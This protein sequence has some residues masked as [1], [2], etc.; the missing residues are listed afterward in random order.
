MAII[1]IVL[2]IL[3]TL[4]AVSAEDVNLTDDSLEANLDDAIVEDLSLS[5][6]DDADLEASSEDNVG[7]ANSAAEDVKASFKTSNCTTYIKGDSF[8][9]KLLD[10]KGNALAKKK[11]HFTL[12]GVKTDVLTTKYGNAKL[13]LNVT[14]GTYTVKYSFDDAGFT[15]IKSSSKILVITNKASKFKASASYTA[16]YKFKNSFDVV[17]S[18]DGI[19]LAG[20]PV[21][22]TVNGKTYHEQSDSKGKASLPIGLYPGIYTIKYSYAGE[23]NINKAEGKSKLISKERMPKKLVKANSVVYRNKISSPFKVKLLDARGNPLKNKKVTFVVNKKKYVKKTD[24]NGIATLNIKLKAG[25]Y[26]IKVSSAKTAY[27][28]KVSKT[29]SINVKKSKV[30]NNGFWVFGAD[31]NK[32]NLDKLQKYGTKH[33]FLNFKAVDLWGKSGVEKFIKKANN[34]DIKVHIWMQVFYANKKWTNPVKNGK[35]DYDLI[36]SKVKLAKKYASLKGVDGV[37]FDYLRYPGT[38]YKYDKGVDAINYF[39]KTASKAIHKINP[40][41]I[42]SAAVMPE[43]SSMKYYYGQDIPTMSKY[44]DVIIP[45]AY[46]GNYGVG[47]TW[48]QKV[49]KSLVK[50]SNGAEVWTGLQSYK[51]DSDVTKLSAKSLIKDSNSAAKGGATGVILFRFGWTNFFNFSNI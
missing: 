23:K 5:Q 7:K 4:S 36:K 51:S 2:T 6:D 20:R 33:I 13:P 45:M 48:I 42:V 39:A 21:D 17:L 12:N 1:F 27:Y 22:F 19:P 49:T 44:V 43:P 10:E 18:V 37:Q 34:H 35:I 15:P 41:I 16:Y 40:K 14:K 25:K 24:N 3:L 38:A 46:K 32:V 26:K 30:R 28:N 47:T 9:V 31:M 11:V 50:K 8:S 29:Y